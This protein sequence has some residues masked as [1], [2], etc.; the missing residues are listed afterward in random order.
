MYA[1][2]TQV[3]LKGGTSE[4]ARVIFETSIVPVAKTQQGF[5]GIYW[6]Q[7]V[8]D[9]RECLALSLW[10]RRADAEENERSG[11]YGEQRD[12]ILHLVVPPVT[13]RGYEVLVGP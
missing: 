1:R 12:K 10:E 2:L 7:S 8:D 11:Y 6:L 4:D 9:P 13:R 5:R 3:R